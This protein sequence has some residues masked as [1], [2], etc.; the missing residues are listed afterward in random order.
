[1]NDAQV[2]LTVLVMGICTYLPRM[3]PLVFLRKK[4]ENPHVSAFL[5]YLPY[6]IL[7][8]MVIPDIFF[9]TASPISGI[10]GAA[11]AFFLAF[12]KKGLLPAAVAAVVTVFLV[13]RL[14]GMIGWIS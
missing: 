14:L 5:T 1:M 3:L 8:A 11:A 6:G 13:E 10:A 12:K 4:I 2:L 9:S 7:T